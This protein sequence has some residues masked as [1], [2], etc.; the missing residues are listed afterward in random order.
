MR[1]H[2]ARDRAWPKVSSPWVGEGHVERRLRDTSRDAADAQPGPRPRAAEAIWR[3]LA[4]VPEPPPGRDPE[5]VETASVPLSI[6]VSPFL[7]G[8]VLP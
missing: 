8:T 1:A 6:P 3:A 2:G 4:L 7:F 5:P